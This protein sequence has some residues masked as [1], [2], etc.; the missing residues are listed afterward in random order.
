MKIM[1]FITGLGMGGAEKVVCELADKLYE[2]GHEVCI[3]YFTGEIIRRPKNNI[4]IFYIPLKISS[5]L[6]SLHSVRKLVD[7]WRP[8]VIHSHMFHANIIARL[9]KINKK[10]LRVIC[11]SHSNYEGG[12]LRMMMYAMTEKL[13][14]VHTN[15]SSNAATALMHAGAVRKR[16]IKAVYNGINIKDYSFNQVENRFLHKEFNLKSDAKVILAIGRIDTPKDYP[17]LLKAFKIIRAIDDN[18]YL[19]IAG[20]GPKKEEIILLGNNLGISSNIKFLGIR[21]DIPKLLNSCDLFISSSAWEGFGLAILEAM[22]CK[23]PIVATETDGAKELLNSENLVEIGNPELLAKKALQ[24]LQ[25]NLRTIEYSGIESFDWN[26][27]SK[28]WL[29]LYE[30]K[31]F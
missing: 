25:S 12:A 13:C 19:F 14:D 20:S 4:Q 17:N 18:V 31:D 6:F 28:T 23:K 15:V 5:L 10:N 8:N 7:Q 22:I 2:L 26:E 27:I 24:K 30:G 9:V 29:S 1:L 21:N 3:V 11:S 16:K